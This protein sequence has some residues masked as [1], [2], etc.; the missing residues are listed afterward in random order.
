VDDQANPQ[1]NGEGPFSPQHL[2]FFVI[3][4]RERERERE[5]TKFNNSDKGVQEDAKM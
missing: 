1:F 4:E 5:Q 2:W 3:K